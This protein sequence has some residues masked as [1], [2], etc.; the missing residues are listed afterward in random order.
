MW[1]DL[2]S[3]N[4]GSSPCAHGRSAR[5]ETIASF[6]DVFG[7]HSRMLRTKHSGGTWAP[8]AGAGLRRLVAQRGCRATPDQLL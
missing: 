2:G 7:M 3:I 8:A 1:R 5:C 6:S 4:A